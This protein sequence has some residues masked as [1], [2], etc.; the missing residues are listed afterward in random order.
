MEVLYFPEIGSCTNALPTFPFANNLNVHSRTFCRYCMR[1]TAKTSQVSVIKYIDAC[2]CSGDMALCFAHKTQ[3]YHFN[4][5]FLLCSCA[6]NCVVLPS[7]LGYYLTRMSLYCRSTY[8]TVDGGSVCP[9]DVSS[10][11]AKLFISISVLISRYG[12]SAANEIIY[13]SGWN[14]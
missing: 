2:F 7:E 4:L 8:W 14:C 9:V 5:P 12:C 6:V 3:L 1:S 13:R 10:V 11:C